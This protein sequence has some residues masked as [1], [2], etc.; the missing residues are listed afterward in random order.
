MS[1]KE[2]QNIITSIFDEKPILKG[3]SP[4]QDFFDRGASSL[5]IV[6][7]QIQVESALGKQ[8]DT[9]K[10]MNFPTING[11]VSVYSEQSA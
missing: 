3:I 10:L 6:D 5:T 9:S 4:D 7:L 1:T 2:I 11:W 8:A